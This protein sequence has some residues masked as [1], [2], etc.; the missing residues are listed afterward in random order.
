MRQFQH[1]IDGAFSDAATTFESVN[2]AN[3]RSWALIPA[4]DG[5]GK[6]DLSVGTHESPGANRER[7]VEARHR[8]RHDQCYGPLDGLDL[9]DFTIVAEILK[10][11]KSPVKAGD[12]D[13]NGG[14]FP[15]NDWKV[16]DEFFNHG[17]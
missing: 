3:G 12:C 16:S 1:Y 13:N 17:R 9:D 4:A 15:Q 10:T 8:H 6:A 11:E 5:R 2:P 14:R 7:L